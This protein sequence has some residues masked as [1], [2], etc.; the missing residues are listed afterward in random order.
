MS[1]APGHSYNSGAAFLQGTSYPIATLNSKLCFNEVSFGFIPH[2]GSSYYL[3]RLPGELGKFLAITGL[4]LTG[5][6]ALEFQA[7]D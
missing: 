3:S 4:P 5:V 2:G 1:V 6:D 7:V